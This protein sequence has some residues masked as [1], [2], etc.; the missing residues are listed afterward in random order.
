[1]IRIETAVYFWFAFLVLL[2]PLDWLASALIAAVFHEVCHLFVLVILGGKIREVRISPGGC[3][4]ESVSPGDWQS[5]LSILAGPAGSLLLTLLADKAPQVAVCGLLHGLYN[6]FPVM[7][8]DGGRLL[9][10]LLGRL[11]PDRG[12]VLA[13]RTGRIFCGTLLLLS[14][15]ASVLL[16]LGNIPVILALIWIIR[17]FPRKIPCKPSQIKVQ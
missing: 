10:L 15:S 8:L 13:L 11:R 16:K 12:E 1:M 14:V 7:P 5:F 6:L 17:F 2:L 9:W 4:I 3:V